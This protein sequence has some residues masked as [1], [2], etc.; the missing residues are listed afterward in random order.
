MLQIRNVCWGNNLEVRDRGPACVLLGVAAL[1]DVTN[2]IM[3]ADI[4]NKLL[5]IADFVCK[6]K[7]RFFLYGSRLMIRMHASMFLEIYDCPT[8]SAGILLL[9][10][11]PSPVFCTRRRL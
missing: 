9:L 1:T 8:T 10:K 11:L 3:G 4:L 2:H 5:N 7:S 6:L